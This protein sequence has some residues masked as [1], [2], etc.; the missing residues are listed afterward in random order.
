MVIL[1]VKLFQSFKSA[2]LWE[3][4]GVYVYVHGRRGEG[5]ISLTAT[6]LLGSWGLPPLIFA[7]HHSSKETQHNHGH[8]TKYNPAPLSSVAMT[9]P[10]GF[11]GD[12]TLQ[13]I[14]I[15]S[16]QDLGFSVSGISVGQEFFKV[17]IQYFARGGNVGKSSLKANSWHSRTCQALKESAPH[18]AYQVANT[19][20]V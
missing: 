17:Y 9:C 19:D 1:A 5:A 4:R 12:Y 13:G 20:S 2:S 8:I 3:R 10:R 14:T 6:I 15:L 18:R 7:W 16:K 11:K